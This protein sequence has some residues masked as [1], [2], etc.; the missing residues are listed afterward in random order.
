MLLKLTNPVECGHGARV[1]DRR[2]RWARRGGFTLI[3]A[4]ICSVIVGLMLAAALN[5][6]GAARS[7]QQH[8]TD[9]QT[10]L[11]LAQSLMDEILDRA[12]ED[13]D[14]PLLLGPELGE[15]QQRR[16]TLDDVDDYERLSENPPRETDGTDASGFNNSWTR[17]VS[18]GWVTSADPTVPC[19]RG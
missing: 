6:A 18:V 7:R 13:A 2:S 8:N 9:R 4:A 10:A 15:D 11:V 3:E 5:A 12:Y 16:E 14:T 17:T 19:R 1:H